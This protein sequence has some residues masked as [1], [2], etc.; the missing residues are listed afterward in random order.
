M[1]LIDEIDEVMVEYSFAMETSYSR[2]SKSRKFK[3]GFCSRTYKYHT[4][5]ADHVYHKEIFIYFCIQK[6]RKLK[7]RKLEKHMIDAIQLSDADRMEFLY[8][9]IRSSPHELYPEFHIKWFKI[10]GFHVQAEYREISNF[11]LKP[12][13]IFVGKSQK[14]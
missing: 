12:I 2:S 7:S 6:S 14:C 11:H 13:V 8:N 5:L 4:I 9:F 3:C 1:T 10:H